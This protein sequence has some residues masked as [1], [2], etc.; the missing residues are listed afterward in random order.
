M[1]ELERKILAAVA[2]L[3]ALAI[4]AVPISAVYA[5]KPTPVAGELFP[6]PGSTYVMRPAGDSDNL[7][8]EISGPHV[9]TGSFEGTSWSEGRW[10]VHRVGTP[11]RW[12]VICVTFTLDVE[13]DGLTGTLT[14]KMDRGNWRII[15]GTGDLANLRGQGTTYTIDPSIFLTGYEG[16]VHFEP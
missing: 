4:L 10:N 9:W 8:V 12:M 15:S 2:A 3:M 5:T 6:T 11:E 1:S 13:Y 14:I 16:Q 7:F